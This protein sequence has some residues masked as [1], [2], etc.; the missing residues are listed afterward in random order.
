[1]TIMKE[2]GTQDWTWDCEELATRSLGVSGL[3]YFW[4]LKS[5]DTSGK[6]FGLNEVVALCAHRGLVL[7]DMAV[8]PSKH[9]EAVL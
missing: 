3:F 6:V 4:T 1:M 2:T 5:R 8:L 9:G 7:Y